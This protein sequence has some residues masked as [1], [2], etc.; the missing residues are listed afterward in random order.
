[1]IFFKAIFEF[2]GLNLSSLSDSAS[3]LNEFEE[4]FELSP[5]EDDESSFSLFVSI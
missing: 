1:M 2:I 5:S 4:L 3:I